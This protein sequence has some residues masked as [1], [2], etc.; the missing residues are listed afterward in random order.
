MRR[1]RHV[2]LL[3]AAIVAAALGGTAA[4]RAAEPGQPGQ[5]G[6]P[7]GVAVAV[8]AAGAAG[9]PG[10]AGGVEAIAGAGGTLRVDQT[11]STV[12]VEASCAG[13]SGRVDFGD[14]TSASLS[15][16]T[17][18]VT[19]AYTATGSHR[20][21]LACGNAQGAATPSVTVPAPARPTPERKRLCLHIASSLLPGALERALVRLGFGICR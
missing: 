2:E 10:S 18:V 14:G 4:A 15:G 13:G 19:H 8:G 20:V 16:T 5:P 6:Q 7:G 9:T 17:G 11:Q 12:R 1:D 21:T 3:A